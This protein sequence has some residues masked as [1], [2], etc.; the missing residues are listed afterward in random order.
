MELEKELTPEQEDIIFLQAQL[1]ETHFDLYK[2]VDKGTLTKSLEKTTEVDPE[3]FKIALQESLALIGDAHTYVSGIF[4]EQPPLLEC[5]EIEGKIYII[6][7]SQEQIFLIGQEVKEING[8]PVIEVMSK[9]SN[10]SS[11]ENKEILLKEVPVFITSPLA[12]KYYGYSKGDII[13][14]TTNA[15][16]TILTKKDGTRIKTKNPLKWKD[17]ELNDPTFLGNKNYRLRVLGNTLLF[18]Y[19]NCTN[20][21]HTDKELDTFKK[22]LLGRVKNSDNLIIDLRQNSGGNT[23]IMADLFA[24]LPEDKK[25]YVA[26]GRKT[27]SSAMHHLF[28]LKNKKN[29]ILI[30]EN[31]G[32]KPNRFGDQKV[33]VL[34]KTHIRVTCSY[35]YFELLP[36]EDKT[37]VEPDIRIPLTIEDYINETDPLNIWI[38]KHLQEQ[39][40]V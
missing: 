23:G 25:I 14:I 18:Q 28:Y 26:M 9:I 30:G 39:S 5:T 12:L 33:I 13:T 15:G 27:F 1:E 40:P 34:P 24:E 8:Y 17:S 7:T 32:Q 21:G 29:A 22:Q 4:N 6:G 16:N 38:K 19:N 11:K 35:K 10:L 3:Y 37:V 20:D 2:N 31:A 36:G